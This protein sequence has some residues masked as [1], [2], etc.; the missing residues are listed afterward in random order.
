MSARTSRRHD[1]PDPTAAFFKDLC[2]GDNE[3]LRH[4]SATLRV[5]LRDGDETEHWY[6]IVDHGAVTVSHRNAK[7]DTVVRTEKKL[8]EGMAEGTV[9][10]MAAMLRGELEIEGDI[11]LPSSLARLFP[12]PPLSRASFLEREKERSR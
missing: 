10:M 3:S 9:N 2:S 1:P 8:F 4:V 5:D 12:G 11:G 6:I 7:A